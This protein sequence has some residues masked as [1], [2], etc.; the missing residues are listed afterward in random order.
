MTTQKKERPT[1]VGVIS[2]THGPLSGLVRSALRDVDYIVHAG[3]IVGAGVID[4]LRGLG[5][6]VAVR[7]NMDGVTTAGGLPWT[8]HAEIAGR[9]FYVLHDLYELDLD[10][11]AAGISVVV[12]G[13][14]HRPDITWRDEV[15]YLNPGSARPRSDG[16][17][18]IARVTLSGDDI[19]PE[20]L[21]LSAF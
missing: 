2:D 3:D 1:R 7:G 21:R 8:A 12:H 5:E 4:D 11:A 15:L 9:S 19:S 18:T 16:T 10:P 6:V 13:H 20:I 14:T 17:A